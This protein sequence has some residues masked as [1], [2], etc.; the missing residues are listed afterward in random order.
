MEYLMLWAVGGVAT[1][2]VA[3]NRGRSFIG[4]LLAG[5]VLGFGGIFVVSMMPVVRRGR[6][7]SRLEE[8]D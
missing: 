1:A 8:S 7:G 4:W 5:L 3:M 6:A 2:I